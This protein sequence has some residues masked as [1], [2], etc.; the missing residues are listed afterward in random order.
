MPTYAMAGAASGCPF[1]TE[2]QL[3]RITRRM[4]AAA[5]SLLNAMSQRGHKQ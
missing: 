1:I 2:S 5:R 4:R 3:E